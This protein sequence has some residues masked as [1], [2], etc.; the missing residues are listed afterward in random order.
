MPINQFQFSNTPP[1]DGSIGLLYSS[2]RLNGTDPD[3]FMITAANVSF[4]SINNIDV[5]PSLEQI[6]AM[7]IILSGSEQLLNH[8][9]KIRFSVSNAA[10]R[11]GYYFLQ[12]D[13]VEVFNR[14]SSLVP[15]AYH[16]LYA[17][18]AHNGELRQP[19]QPPTSSLNPALLAHNNHLHN[20][21]SGSGNLD[22]ALVFFEPFLPEDIT[23]NDYE[24][25]LSNATIPENSAYR[26]EVDRNESQI[27]PGNFDAI[28][29]SSAVNADVQ[30]SNYTTLA[31]INPRYEGSTLDSGSLV[32]DD[33]GL[34]FIQFDGS[35]HESDAVNATIAA[36]DPAERNIQEFF[37]NFDKGRIISA[38]ESES[39]YGATPQI[40][41]YIYRFD[42]DSR[43]YVRV[44]DS[45]IFILE[46]NTVIETNEVGQLTTQSIVS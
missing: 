34:S 14:D 28:V 39:G 36:I 31:H 19:L 1:G 4:N 46:T 18:Q 41:H 23:N 45:K 44:V 37:F 43:R 30:E 32:G 15:R 29:S 8:P 40:S 26:F 9:T 20:I 2:S 7:V 17:Y 12:F 5:V 6:E 10:R 24:A 38:S 27:M 22:N 3:D 16:N 11:S 42:N 35:R 13:G 25:L 21:L 33:P